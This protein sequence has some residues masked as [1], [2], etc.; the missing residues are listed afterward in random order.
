MTTPE[1][2]RDRYI[3]E[4][5]GAT[6]VLDS[7][8]SAA[9]AEA[10]A[11]G[12]VAEWLALDGTPGR[13]AGRVRD[14][15]PLAADLIEW[16]DSGNRPAASTGQ[17]ADW[18][19]DVGRHD[20]TRAV[21][22]RRSGANDAG[23]ILEYTAPSGDRHDLSVSIDDGR[24]VGVAVGPEGLAIAAVD[25]ERDDVEVDELDP[26]NALDMVRVALDRPLGELSPAAE[27]S[28]PLVLRRVGFLPSDFAGAGQTVA[29][30][31][32]PERFA[33]DDQ[34][35]ADV[36]QSALRK[37]LAEDQ[38]AAVDD[39]LASFVKQ[40]ANN[41]PD[42]LTV[43]DIAGIDPSK[44]V[45]VDG[46]IALAGAYLAPVDLGA[47]TDPQFDALIELEPA[48]WVGVIL[49]MSRTA[50]GTEIEGDTLVNFINKAPEITTTI[51]KADA[52]R[53]AWTFEQ[54]L[55]SWEVTGVLTEDGEVSGAA[56]WLLPR[57]AIAAWS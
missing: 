29:N 15:S 31:T 5:T 24:I 34:Y 51:P 9:I 54:M 33:E 35:A 57:A 13:L 55:Y 53:L 11:S 43:F 41:D 20:L 26:S 28:L 36:V 49:G 25:A 38:P 8:E 27:A 21:Q 56:R 48:D 3:D 37:L 12:A 47:H 32:L 23:V 45:T 40:V 6:A 2:F 46:L 50:P 16:I 44:P 10:W 17:A 1:H 4:L 7:V 19:A 30:R 42:S 14:H 18:V 52:P 39:A 22:L